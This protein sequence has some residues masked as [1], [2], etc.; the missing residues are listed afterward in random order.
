MGVIKKK[1][2]YLVSF[3]TFKALIETCNFNQ[4]GMN[5]L[6]LLIET[7]VQSLMDFNVILI[8]YQLDLNFFQISN[9]LE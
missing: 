5:Y 7:V 4:M 6:E 2:Y 1:S 8:V 3:F 9:Q